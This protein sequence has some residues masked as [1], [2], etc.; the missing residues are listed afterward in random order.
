[1]KEKGGEISV[2]NCIQQSKE[3]E[4]KASVWR[5]I[6]LKRGEGGVEEPAR[7]EHLQSL[8][9]ALLPARRTTRHTSAFAAAKAPV[10][11]TTNP[12]QI[13]FLV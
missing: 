5:C 9:P 3:I 2:G 12:L 7:L 4:T 11:S 8:A 6:L 13:I 10:P 1:M